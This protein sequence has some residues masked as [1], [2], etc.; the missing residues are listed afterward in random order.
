MAAQRLPAAGLAAQGAGDETLASA[1]GGLAV[2]AAE[3]GWVLI[4]DTDNRLGRSSH[5]ASM[6]SSPRGTMVGSHHPGAP[7]NTIDRFAA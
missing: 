6:S 7:V 4:G 3:D 1:L 2:E 5:P